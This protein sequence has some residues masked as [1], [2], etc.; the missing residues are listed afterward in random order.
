MN[1]TNPGMAIFAVKN[2]STGESEKY[3]AS[4]AATAIFL[5]IE[6]GLGGEG[7]LSATV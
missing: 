3:E 5:A 6:D 7:D 1:P 2:L 4:D